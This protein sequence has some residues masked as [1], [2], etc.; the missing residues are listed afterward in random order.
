MDESRKETHGSKHHSYRLKPAILILIGLVVGGAIYFGVMAWY[1]TGVDPGGGPSG[2]GGDAAKSSSAAEGQ[3]NLALPSF[4]KKLFLE[5]QV[6]WM[7]YAAI[8]L[9]VAL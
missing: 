2:F 7:Q 8:G 5:V 3:G 9:G 6:M 4:S 1:F